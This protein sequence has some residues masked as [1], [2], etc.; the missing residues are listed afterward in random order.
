MVWESV[1]W[2]EK[3][4]LKPRFSRKLPL[5]ESVFQGG[6]PFLYQLQNL[7][8][9]SFTFNNSKNVCSC[10]GP[11]TRGCWNL[12]EP[13][14]PWR[15]GRSWRD[16]GGAVPCWGDTLVESGWRLLVWGEGGEGETKRGEKIKASFKILKTNRAKTF[17]WWLYWQQKH[18]QLWTIY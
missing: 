11:T 2:M 9:Q 13:S 7:M 4:G 1:S 6:T 14:Y 17:H 12:E 16:W 10:A 15:R 5:C 8:G 18:Q 3:H